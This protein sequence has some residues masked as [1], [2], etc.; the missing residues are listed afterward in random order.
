MYTSKLVYKLQLST[1]KAVLKAEMYTS[2]VKINWFIW[3]KIKLMAFLKIAKFEQK[4]L[5]LKASKNCQNDDISP[6]LVTLLATSE[7]R[8][9]RDPSRLKKVAINITRV[10]N[11]I[12]QICAKTNNSQAAYEICGQLQKKIRFVLDGESADTSLTIFT[13]QVT[14]RA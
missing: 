7:E 5:S 8:F 11:R 14:K 13:N 4:K 3:P 1:S 2:R 9:Y 12:F 10:Q 6:H